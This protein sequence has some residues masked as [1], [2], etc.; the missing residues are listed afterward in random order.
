[1]LVVFS[2]DAAEA[3]SMAVGRRWGV[4]PF[5]DGGGAVPLD[6]DREVICIRLEV[7]WN[8]AR[9]DRWDEVDSR[10][11]MGGGGGRIDETS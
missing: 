4:G 9:R 3:A 1:M 7:G 5:W 10:R 6:A 2:L 8:I 11:F